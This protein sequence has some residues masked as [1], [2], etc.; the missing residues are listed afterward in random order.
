M[1]LLSD[2]NHCQHCAASVPSMSQQFFSFPSPPISVSLFHFGNNHKGPCIFFFFL[3]GQL[4]LRL[5]FFFFL[6]KAHHFLP[7]PWS[8][9]HV[10]PCLL[11]HYHFSVCQPDL[12]HLKSMCVSVKSLCWQLATFCTAHRPPPPVHARGFMLSK[13]GFQW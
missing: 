13:K 2:F 9:P 11:G 7:S 5:F 4:I 6:Y 3:C 8:C 1:G 12:Q 10:L